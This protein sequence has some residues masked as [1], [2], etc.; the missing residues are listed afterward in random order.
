MERPMDMFSI[1]VLIACLLIARALFFKKRK[2]GDPNR[3]L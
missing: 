2:P 3:G 1:F